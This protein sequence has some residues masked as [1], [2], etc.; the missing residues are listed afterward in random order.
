MKLFIVIFTFELLPNEAA[1]AIDRNRKKEKLQL[2]TPVIFFLMCLYFVDT[3]DDFFFLT[4]PFLTSSKI[5]QGKKPEFM[6][7]K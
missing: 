4:L 7:E 3:I 6:I 1:G 2:D 5:I